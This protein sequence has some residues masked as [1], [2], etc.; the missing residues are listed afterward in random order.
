MLKLIAVI[1]ATHA[2]EATRASNSRQT[3]QTRFH[4]L[5]LGVIQEQR[6][7]KPIRFTTVEDYGPDVAASVWQSSP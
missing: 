7:C 5:L 6:G 3:P 4:A 1:K 2:V